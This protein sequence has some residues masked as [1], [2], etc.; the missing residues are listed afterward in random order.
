[1]KSFEQLNEESNNANVEQNNPAPPQ[2]QKQLSD[3][4]PESNSPDHTNDSHQVPSST[5]HAE[6]SVLNSKHKPFVE[7]RNIPSE[8]NKPLNRNQQQSIVSENVLVNPITTHM[9]QNQHPVNNNI[10]KRKLL[11]ERVGFVSVIMEIIPDEVE[12]FFESFNIS[13]HAIIFTSIVAFFWCLMKLFI[14]FVSSSKKVRELQD[15]ICQ[16]QRKLYYFEAEKDKIKEEYVVCRDEVCFYFNS[17]IQINFPPFL[18]ESLP[19]IKTIFIG[20][21]NVNIN[22]NKKMKN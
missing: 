10:Y 13:L 22:W 11:A 7:N 20:L 6:G 14:F 9:E 17:T 16:T 3:P 21:K 8:D 2:Q 1:M 15:T 19:V 5:F 4:L 12:L 18:N